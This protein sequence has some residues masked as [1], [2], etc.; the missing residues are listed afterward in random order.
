MSAEA[1]WTSEPF[2]IVRGGE[3]GVAQWLERGALSISLAGVRFR[4]PLGAGFSEK[5]HVVLMLC[6]WVRHFTLTRFT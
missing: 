6:A 5:Y 2:C 4:T 1:V 3:G